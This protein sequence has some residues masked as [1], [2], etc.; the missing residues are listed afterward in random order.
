[1]DELT[2][3]S[4]SDPKS[5][6]AETVM[7]SVCCTLSVAPVDVCVWIHGSRLALFAKV[8]T[9]GGRTSL[10]ALGPGAGAEVL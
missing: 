4:Q 5:K 6:L 7:V 2:H 3:L 10:Q 1:M 9:S 8:R